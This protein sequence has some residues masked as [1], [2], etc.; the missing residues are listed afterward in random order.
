MTPSRRNSGGLG[1]WARRAALLVISAGLAIG[2]AKMVSAQETRLSQ[3]NGMANGQWYT[4][5][6]GCQYSRTGR[7]GETVWFLT[8]I[9][10]G[11]VCPEFIIEKS[12]DGSYRKP[13]LVKG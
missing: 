6:S 5:E 2:A 3:G 7:P 13:N 12:I 8:A 11:A 9:P 4:N 1:A 10:R